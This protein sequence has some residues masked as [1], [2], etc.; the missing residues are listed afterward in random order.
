MRSF[1]VRFCISLAYW[2]GIDFYGF[3]ICCGTPQ[4]IGSFLHNRNGNHTREVPSC[5]SLGVFGIQCACIAL[6]SLFLCWVWGHDCPVVS[7]RSKFFLSLSIYLIFLSFSSCTKDFISQTHVHA[8]FPWIVMYVRMF[9]E[10]SHVCP[11][12]FLFWED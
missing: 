3:S 7:Y 1:S 4:A 11:D 8:G 10:N 5:F 12:F 2:E 6:I 9:A